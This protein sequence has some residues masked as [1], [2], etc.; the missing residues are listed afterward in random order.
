MLGSSVLCLVLYLAVAVGVYGYGL[1][2]WGA[3]RALYFA[4]VTMTVGP[5]RTLSPIWLR[6]FWHYLRVGINFV[7]CI[8]CLFCRLKYFYTA[9]LII[10]IVF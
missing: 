1:E 6:P 5:Y 4:V 10:I 2:N 8:I 3:V 9:K 7:R